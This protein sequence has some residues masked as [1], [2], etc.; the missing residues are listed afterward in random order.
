VD[1][2]WSLLQ[3]SRLRGTMS[4]RGPRRARWLARFSFASGTG[5]RRGCS[6]VQRSGQF[7][8]SGTL[9]RGARPVHG[10]MHCVAV[11]NAR[12]RTEVRG[13][14]PV[15]R[16]VLQKSTS[17]VVRRSA[18]S[19]PRGVA[20]H[21][22][23]S[24]PLRATHVESRGRRGERDGAANRSK[25]IGSSV[26]GGLDR[27]SRPPVTGMAAKSVSAARAGAV[28][29]KACD[30]AARAATD[31]SP[32]RLEVILEEDNTSCVHGEPAGG[33]SRG[34]NPYFH[35][36][37]WGNP[38]DAGSRAGCGCSFS[39]IV[40]CMS[41]SPVPRAANRRRLVR[42]RRAAWRDG[43]R[44]FVTRTSAEGAREGVRGAS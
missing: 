27:G 39:E 4:G 37:A 30:G 8:A 11:Q 22:V 31:L 19:E 13:V 20:A 24:Q 15:S 44:T 29:A 33:G 41:R 6:G 32:A 2:T 7:R 36:S 43:S 1:G 5:E 26:E 42:R 14:V 35:R 12:R 25:E 3:A 17:D 18:P 23:R 21:L 38:R 9:E 16:I 40:G 10:D 34:V 28:G